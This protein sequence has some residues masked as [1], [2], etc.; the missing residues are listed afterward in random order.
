[1]T[2]TPLRLAVF[3]LGRWGV[4]LLRN[5]LAQVEA[6]VVA[7]VD[8]MPENLARIQQQ[9]D[10][11]ESIAIL[12]DW[13]RA[14]DLAD[15]DAVVVATPA[16]THY[17]LIRAALTRG[18]HV[19][20][21]KP[22]TLETASAIELC[23][24]AEKV[25]RQLVIDHTYLFHPAVVR[26]KAALRSGELGDR[27]YGYATRTHLAPV[28]QDV[29]ALWDLA[30]HDIAILNHWLEEVPC[31]VSARGQTWLQPTAGID[32]AGLADV[33]WATIA[34]P[35]GFRATLHLAW[36]NCDK[37]RRIGIVGDR[38]TLIFDELAATP[39]IIQR[40]KLQPQGS[41]FQPVNQATEVLEL[42]P[43]EPLARVCQHF[44]HCALHN[45]PSEISPGW[46]GADLVRV[47]VALS[48]SMQQDGVWMRLD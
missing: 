17:E 28:R 12:Q 42:V 23:Q 30:I 22:L 31:G 14:I 24:L 10:L 3:G 47:L 20:A 45:H 15:L 8:P 48:R 37:Q 7:I 25:Q 43:Q 9:F 27:R 18:L 33:V 29:D 34:Y 46:L 39:L 44:L 5:F 41:G 16:V 13:Q 2:Q 1:M 35:S 11:P 26:G 40:G 36:L 32:G 6:Q 19:L 21:E 38:G 4:H